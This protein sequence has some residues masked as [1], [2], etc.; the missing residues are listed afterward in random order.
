[1]SANLELGREISNGNVVQRTRAQ[2]E[3]KVGRFS[4]WLQSAF[5][6]LVN[7]DQAGTRVVNFNGVT[8]EIYTELFGHICKK[9]DKDGNYVNPPQ[10]DSF[11]YVSGYKSALKK[12]YKLNDIVWEDKVEA[13]VSLFLS[14]YKRKIAELKKSGEKP[15]IEGKMP[16]KFDAYRYLCTHSLQDE[17]R[18][19]E[20]VTFGH[21]FLV[22]CWNLIARCNSVASIMYDHITWKKIR[23]KLYFQVTKEI[24]RAI[25]LHPNMFTLILFA[26]RYVLF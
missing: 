20:V 15:L 1:M 12:H 7:Q 18:D 23:W 13:A 14:G 19:P 22:F 21:L 16:M 26:L 25:I 17:T 11:Q 6:N 4:E 24:K 2:Y 10:Y 5:P 8:S 9:K 3:A